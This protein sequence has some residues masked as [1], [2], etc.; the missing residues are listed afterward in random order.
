SITPQEMKLATSV[1]T[2]SDPQRLLGAINCIRP[3]LGITIK[4]MHPLFSVLKGD[5]DLASP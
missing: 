1:Q 5:R 4:D 2:L 3:L